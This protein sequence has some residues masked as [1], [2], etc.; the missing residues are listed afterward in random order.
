[1]DKIVL[2]SMIQLLQRLRSSVAEVCVDDGS[3]YSLTCQK[4][5]EWIDSLA[6]IFINRITIYEKVSKILQQSNDNNSWVASILMLKLYNNQNILSLREAYLQQAEAW[7]GKNHYDNPPSYKIIIDMYNVGWSDAEDKWGEHKNPGYTNLWCACFTSAVAIACG[8][9]ESVPLN[10]SSGE[11]VKLAKKYNIWKNKIMPDESACLILYGDDEKNLEHVGIVKNVDK[12]QVITIEGNT[13]GGCVVE[14]K[15]ERKD[16]VGYITPKWENALYMYKNESILLEQLTDPQ[17][18][19]ISELRK[20]IEEQKNN[21]LWKKMDKKQRQRTVRLCVLSEQIVKHKSVKEWERNNDKSMENLELEYK[22]EIME[23]KLEPQIP[24]K[25]KNLTFQDIQDWFADKRD[26]QIISV[27]FEKEWTLTDFKSVL[28]AIMAMPAEINQCL[29]D[30][31]LDKLIKQNKGNST[32]LYAVLFYGIYL[33][34]REIWCSF[35][36]ATN[37]KH[38]SI[39]WTTLKE[40]L[41]GNNVCTDTNSSPKFLFITQNITNQEQHNERQ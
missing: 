26:L 13:N 27:D 5:F 23:E 33:Q 22:E 20:T 32:A 38:G 16:I 7:L 2:E 4:A 19:G 14:K 3:N 40:W 21:E 18:Q 12:S 24:T 31:D 11:L 30:S 9:Q 41:V 15:C 17:K 36:N 10:K 25:V 37:G 1:M 39:K 8:A 35:V 6:A 29:S 28:P 34:E